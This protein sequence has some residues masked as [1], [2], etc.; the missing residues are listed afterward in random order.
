MFIVT[1]NVTLNI[2]FFSMKLKAIRV[3]VISCTTSW[4]LLL[5]MHIFFFKD[6]NHEYPTVLDR[7]GAEWLKSPAM[8]CPSWIKEYVQ[9]ILNTAENK[10]WA[11]RIEQIIHGYLIQPCCCC[12][13]VVLVV[14]CAFS[15][16]LRV[17]Q[18]IITN[19]RSECELKCI[20]ALGYFQLLKRLAWWNWKGF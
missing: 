18:F 19:L 2:F 1:S 3:R 5:P 15:D 7:W 13:R 10:K 16:F 20:L 8:N 14:D 12:W 4:Q 11:K 17:V 6:E 9:L